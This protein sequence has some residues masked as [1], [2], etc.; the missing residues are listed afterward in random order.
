VAGVR[1]LVAVALPGPHRDRTPRTP[2]AHS[3]LTLRTGDGPNL[4]PFYP[5]TPPAVAPGVWVPTEP[6]PQQGVFAGI[7]QLTPF[8][9]TSG[10]QYRPGPPP[11]LTSDEYAQDLNE[12]KAY[13]RVDSAVRTSDQA[14]AAIWWQDLSASV[15][16]NAAA[17][18][19][20][21]QQG[22]S[23]P[24]KARLFALP[25]LASL[26]A[27][28]SVFDTKYA[29]FFWRPVTAIQQA[30][31]DGNLTTIAD[32]SWQPLLVTPP[33]PEYSSGHLCHSGAAAAII[34]A[35]LGPDN[36]F[37]LTDPMSSPAITRSFANIPAGHA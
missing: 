18:Q 14:N 1:N 20:S 7:A 26:D 27:V 15:I 17:R 13:G 37:S 36:A 8:T 3:T 22:L 34:V 23:V 6:G 29:Y 9:M 12:V 28:I 32:P 4:N 33:F 35:L 11:T 21:S 5:Y 24:E 30:D 16:W 2:R 31:T 10:S 19:I 25:N